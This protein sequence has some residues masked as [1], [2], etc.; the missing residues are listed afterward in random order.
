[1]RFADRFFDN[2]VHTPMQAIVS[3]AL[4]EEKRDADAVARARASLDTAYAWLERRM[5]NREWVAGDCFSAEA[6]DPET[7]AAR[8]RARIAAT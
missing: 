3:D 1:V 4:R 6:R 8:R 7:G 2:Y 5:Q